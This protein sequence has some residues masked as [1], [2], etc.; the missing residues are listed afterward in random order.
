M[1]RRCGQ[2][3]E[4]KVLAL[5][6]EGLRISCL[7]ASPLSRRDN[8]VLWQASSGSIEKLKLEIPVQT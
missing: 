5:E 8:T 7:G 3:A 1:H 4:I 6:E 2:S